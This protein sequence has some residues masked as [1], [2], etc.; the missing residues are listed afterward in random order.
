MRHAAG[1]F[2]PIE[3]KLKLEGSILAMDLS[4]DE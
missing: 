1:G 2:M 4:P 3:Q